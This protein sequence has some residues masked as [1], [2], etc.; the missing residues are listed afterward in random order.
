MNIKIENID[1]QI[2][3]DELDGFVPMQIHDA[4]TH[5]YRW[6]DSTAPENENPLLKVI[7]GD[8]EGTLEDLKKVDE[9]LMPDRKVVSRFAMGFPFEYCNFE[10]A[11]EFVRLQIGDDTNSG[12]FALVS[13]KTTDERLESMMTEEG[14]VGVK[15]YRFY[16]ITNDPVNCRIEDYLPERLIKVLNRNSGI[17][18]LH[19]SKKEG[20]ADIDNLSDLE[21]LTDLYPNVQWILC[22]AARCYLPSFLERN[23]DRLRNIPNLW[24]DTSSVCDSDVFTLLIDILGADKVMYGSDD[25][26][27]SARRGKYINFGNAWVELNEQNSPFN[28]DYCDPRMTYI[29]YESIRHLKRAAMNLSLSRKQIQDLFLGNAVSLIKKVKK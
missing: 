21:R 29:R 18:M 10:T 23:A 13:H 7:Y 22:H 25:L 9:V 5:L 4:H 16:S 19:L 27:V 17:V 11:N 15:P 6:C 2:W 20:I 28:P 14:F 26:S 1:T 24:S 8:P 3:Q 12:A